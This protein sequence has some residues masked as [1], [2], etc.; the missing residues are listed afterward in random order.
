MSHANRIPLEKVGGKEKRRRGDDDDDEGLDPGNRNPNPN[1]PNPNPNNPTLIIGSLHEG[2]G[3]SFG[4]SFLC[5]PYW[6]LRSNVGFPVM[7]VSETLQVE[8]IKTVRGQKTAFQN[9]INFWKAHSRVPR[10][11]RLD[12]DSKFLSEEAKEYLTEAGLWADP[13]TAET[14][15]QAGPAEKAIDLLSRMAL[16]WMKYA[17]LDE[18]TYRARAMSFG[19]W[20]IYSG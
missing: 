19:T 12:R 18:H 20:C 4:R 8:L 13:T 7:R 1:N 16:T 2:F 3:R 6:M 17:G 15:R 9:V 10:R 11:I 14:H 5:A